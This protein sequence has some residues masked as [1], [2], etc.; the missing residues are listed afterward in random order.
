MIIVIFPKNK[1]K[2]LYFTFI[3]HVMKFHDDQWLVLSRIT[4]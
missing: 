4:I 1:V 3:K 2:E